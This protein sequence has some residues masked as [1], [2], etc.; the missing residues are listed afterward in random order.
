VFGQT[1]FGVRAGALLCG[2]ITSIFV[3]KLTR[4]LF[5][6]A[7][8]LAALLLVQALPFFFLSGLLMTPD[9]PLTA[10]W[11]ASLYYLERALV[12]GRPGNWWRAGLALGIGALSK[13]SIGL[14]VP[15]TLA[16]M[17]WDRESRRWWLR[18]QPYAAAL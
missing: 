5:G 7:A 13:Y 12:A 6:A 9:A 15:V 18:G 3:Y 4:N 8:A 2:A 1:E 11:A 14:L 10:A 17:S 16:F